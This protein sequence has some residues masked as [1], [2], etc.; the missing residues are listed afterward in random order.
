MCLF[1]CAVLLVLVQVLAPL[2]ADT[3]GSQ[4]LEP[5]GTFPNH[6][7]NP[8]NKEAMAAA[9]DMVK[10]SGACFVCGPA[11]A[12]LLRLQSRAQLGVTFAAAVISGTWNASGPCCSWP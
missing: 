11:G 5:D 7:P 9:V 6:I 8:E 3:T 12:M 10:K 4:F 2:G 1:C